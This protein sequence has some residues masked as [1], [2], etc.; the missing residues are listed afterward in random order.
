MGWSSPENRSKK[1]LRG[2]AWWYV[3]IIPASRKLRQKNTCSGLTWVTLWLRICVTHMHAKNIEACVFVVSDALKKSVAMV[4]RTHRRKGLYSESPGLP[5]KQSVRPQAVCWQP[6]DWIILGVYVS[7]AVKPVNQCSFNTTCLQLHHEPF[8]Q[9]TQIAHRCNQ[10]EEAGP[11]LCVTHTCEQVGCT[12]RAHI[13]V[14]RCN[15]SSRQTSPTF[16]SFGMSDKK[17][18]ATDL[19]LD[20]DNAWEEKWATNP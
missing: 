13:Q 16:F 7:V 4:I 14:P 6:P 11:C 5:W 20:E 8:V 17:W 9:N 19:I 1:V 10:C 12:K 2:L 3:V 15:H 18:E